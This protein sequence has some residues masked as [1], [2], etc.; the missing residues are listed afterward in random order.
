[1]VKAYIYN[2][3]ERVQKVIDNM[4]MADALNFAK[5]IILQSYYRNIDLLVCTLFIRKIFC[6]GHMTWPL[7][8]ESLTKYVGQGA[9][10]DAL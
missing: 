9:Q 5:I 7:W 4:K 2:Y 3:I 10:W 1:M 6:K 8:I